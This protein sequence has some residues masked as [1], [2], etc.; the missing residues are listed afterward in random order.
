MRKKNFRLDTEKLT[1]TTSWTQL[2]NGKG[3]DSTKGFI[4]SKKLLLMIS[5][6]LPS[7]LLNVQWITWG[8][9]TGPRDDVMA[10][11]A[12][13]LL[14]WQNTASWGSHAAWTLT[15]W[16]M[17]P[18]GHDLMQSGFSAT[19]VP[20]IN[21]WP[22]ALWVKWTSFC[23]KCVEQRQCEASYF[24]HHR[25]ISVKC[26]TFLSQSAHLDSQATGPKAVQEQPDVIT[27]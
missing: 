23:I 18:Q 10:F 26:N 25:R 27:W 4:D 14:R 13:P 15:S 21:C 22:K 11:H 20:R 12:R 9:L 8:I 6:Q 7:P 19:Q 2:Q 5:K 1:V 24:L 3:T 17:K 16:P